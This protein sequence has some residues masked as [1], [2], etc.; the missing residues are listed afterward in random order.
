MSADMLTPDKVF[1]ISEITGIIKDVLE[2]SFPEIWVEGE[3]SNY[4]HHTS[5][6]RYFSLKD[7][8]ATLRCVMWRTTA[9][10]L[11]FEPDN[12]KRVRAFGSLNV[13][14]PQGS[15]Q[16]VCAQLVDAGIG[17]LEI[18]F[19]KIKEKLLREGL[20][21]VDRKQPL[22]EYPATVGIVTSPTGAAIADMTRTIAQRFRGIQIVLAPAR[23][24][25]EG[26][27]EEIAAAIAV[28]NRRDDI[29][30]LI[31]GRGGGSLE[32]L[33]P[34]NEEIVARAIADSRIPVVSAVGHEVD[35]TIADMVADFRAPTPTGAAERIT[36]GWV[37][38]RHEF[39]P[40]VNRLARGV[41][42]LV[43]SYRQQWERLHRSHALRRPADL[44][45]IWSQRLDDTTER[46]ARAVLQANAT[47]RSALDATLGKLGALSPDG[48]LQRGYSITRL[49]GSRDALRGVKQLK[50]GQQIETTLAEGRIVSAVSETTAKQSKKH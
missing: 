20:F 18:A 46:M 15:Y 31:V 35:F 38:A 1:T 8:S 12:G 33:W 24:Q 14:P 42:G 11:R 50:R 26:A 40:L 25:G 43:L 39:G 37:R 6:H 22:P 28:F 3:V 13:Y 19:Q 10:G 36:D 41:A 47:R 48:V 4:K 2:S 49:A 17:P 34:F 27:A 30:V 45:Q 23:V 32:D 29:D 44:F 21:D 16:L 7:E 5:G 9:R